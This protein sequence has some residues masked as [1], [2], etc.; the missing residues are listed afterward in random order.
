[1]RPDALLDR[2][3][4]VLT[5]GRRLAHAL[6]LAHAR[7]AQARGLQVWR[8]PRILPWTGWLRQ[9]WLERRAA[10]V[11]DGG[12]LRLLN[13]AQTRLLWS[14][15]VAA[16][17]EGGTLL[18]PASAARVAARA[19]RRMQDYL[20]PVER[21]AEAGQLEA[22]AL[23]GWC[24]DF[25][26]RCAALRAI[27]EASLA[28]W[29]ADTGF[30]PEE[31][32][33]LAGFDLV[34][35]ALQRLIE[36]WQGHGKVEALELE[37]RPADIVQV[38]AARDTAQELEL[39]AR[40]ARAQVE[41]GRSRIGVVVP[42]LQARRAHVARAFEDVFAPGHRGAPGSAGTLPVA[43][44]APAPLSSY[45]LVDAAVLILTLALGERRATHVG[46][47]LRSPFIAGGESERSLRA[48][49]DWRLRSEQR[50]RWDW[51][52]L[53][54]WAGVTRCAVLQLKA[55]AVTALLRVGTEAARPSQWAERFHEWLEAS[56][57]PG[58]RTL[59]SVE[60]QT[61][62][63]FHAALAEL[64]TLDT[65]SGRVSLAKALGRLQEIL[66]ETPFEPETPLGAVTVIDPTTVGGM[67]FEA[68]WV[69]GLDAASL[70]G[71][72]D[73]DPLLPL[74]VQ[75]AAGL[76]EACAE[77]IQRR[78][79][80][81]LDGWLRSTSELVL[82]WPKQDGEALLQPSPL[83]A[84]WQQLAAE[85]LG[86]AATRP[87]R[88]TLFEHRP[89]L[90]ELEDERAPVLPSS[91]ARG[92]ARTLELQSRCA[93]RAQAELR[94]RAQPL[95]RIRVGVE[96]LD[97]GTIVH[98][99]LA[100]VWTSLGSQAAL[101]ALDE[102]LL[103]QQVR[104]SAQRRAMQ[105]LRPDARYRVR[106][107]TLEIESVVSQVMRLLAIEKQRP[108]FTVRVAE[109]A[110]THAIGGMTITLRPDRIDELASGGE[111]LIDYKVG[112]SHQ[113]R[114]WLES[115]EGRPSKPQLP[116]YGLAHRARLRGLAF[117][118]LAPGSVEYRGWSDGA[119]AGAGVLPY[120]A[121]VRL[122]P[123]APQ[124][125]PALLQRWQHVLTQLA[126]QFV[127]GAARPDPLPQECANCH[128]S[129][130]CRIDERR[131]LEAE[132]VQ[133]E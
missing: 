12:P 2:H 104:A 84:P 79:R 75:R 47:V 81:R 111:L 69:L 123:D 29:A 99:V 31:T 121:G 4:T 70:P 43:L 11:V 89:R 8:T 71:P 48:L 33:A 49:A 9:Q 82:S 78:A 90:Q 115:I 83:L 65:V 40:W 21:L 52:E 108:P 129:T 130:L 6:R 36:Y 88:H 18:H 45:P 96:P 35:P 105:A 14:D 24:R 57:W 112:D 127:G 28:R 64:G 109:E 67:S 72:I 46:R 20:I 76:P 119:A 114:H 113:P 16:S 59:D 25:Q 95:P 110:E 41:R 23:L 55:R 126:Q 103:H 62:G 17:A 53:E 22:R 39:A 10:G 42:D 56:G 74:E 58:E 91:E 85:D 86:L 38:V 87:L 7:H 107:A 27:D 30:V 94:L 106:L 124:D 51:F 73:P 1:M 66:R 93:F 19:W 132:L 128:L 50:D 98:G 92:G 60:H 97:R 133:D 63:K 117:V 61:L 120:P 116:L 125:W 68:L 77:G 44:A 3:V 118:V 13:A 37:R 34:P 15:V 54:R 5:A 101:L 122:R 100:D 80:M 26:Q 32:V 131:Q 102:A